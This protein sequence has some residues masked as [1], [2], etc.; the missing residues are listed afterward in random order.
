MRT[1][2]KAIV[3]RI[4]LLCGPFF[5]EGTIPGRDEF[6]NVFH[7]VSDDG[8]GGFTRGVDVVEGTAKV[9]GDNISKAPTP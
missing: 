5:R 6:A 7:L 4:N 9:S 3:A 8:E 1:T 2:S